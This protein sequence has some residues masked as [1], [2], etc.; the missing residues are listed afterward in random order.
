MAVNPMVTGCNFLRGYAEGA[1]WEMASRE[2]ASSVGFY[3]MIYEDFEG[4]NTDTMQR[5]A[6][7]WKLL[8]AAL[9]VTHHVEPRTEAG[10]HALVG[11]RYGLWI[12][13]TV[14]NTPDG[15]KQP[16]FQ[17]PMGLISAQVSRDIPTVSV[18][19]VNTGCSACHSSLLYGPDGE[20][21][22]TAWIGLPSSHFNPER[23]AAD[24]YAAFR[25]AV[26]HEADA[27]SAVE[28]VFPDVSPDE[29]Q[30]LRRFVI[31]ALRKR[32]DELDG[33]L[34]RFTPYSNGGAGLTNGVG[35]IQLYLGWL[36]ETERSDDQHGYAA[37]P[38][39]GGLEFKR[40]VLYDGVYAPPGEAHFGAVDDPRSAAHR[41]Q[42]AGMITLVTVGTLGVDPHIAVDQ[43][44]PPIRDVIDF[45][46]DAYTPPPFPGVIDDA[47]AD[48]GA[49][50]FAKR[51]QTCHG[52][53]APDDD[54]RWQMVGFPNKGIP[55]EKVGTDPWRASAVT[56]S[57]VDRFKQTPL[58]EVIDPMQTGRYVAPPLT[59]LWATAP[60]F[61]NNSVPTVYH[62]LTPAERP[63]RFE[64]GGHKLDYTLLGIAGQLDAEGVWRMPSGYQPRMLPEV[65]DTTAA[66]R[67]NAG[68][69]AFTASIDPSGRAA[70]LEFLKRL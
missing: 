8:G 6:V 55:L 24:A 61:H 40:A 58:G 31:P 68:H 9:V 34:G 12:P 42:M 21:T 65:Y 49:R 53:Y 29:L 27:L 4:I 7:A 13:A 14:G 17:R 19:V 47:L 26:D 57:V 35:T 60:Y 37:I 25:W 62:V 46:F 20:L 10:F 1:S 43:N 48:E 15:L 18:E 30:T 2:D 39:L 66:G 64:V 41:D 23:L 52:E 32:L 11:E 56:A 63:A 45:L 5:S 3:R 50:I 44:R 54:G 28:A 59:G 22:D 51:C 36:P 16:V 69:D 33:S 67:S 70:L 38:S